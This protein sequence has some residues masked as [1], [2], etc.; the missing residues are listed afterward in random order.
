MLWRMWLQRWGHRQNHKRSLILKN[1]TVLLFVTWTVRIQLNTSA[2]GTLTLATHCLSALASFI[3]LIPSYDM[4]S[5]ITSF[6]FRNGNHC[7]NILSI[8]FSPSFPLSLLPSSSIMRCWFLLYWGSNPTWTLWM[9]R[10][11]HRATHG[12]FSLH[13]T[14]PAVL[15]QE[16]FPFSFL[17]LMS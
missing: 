17:S 16:H 12:L 1:I 8:P 5:T 13:T 4:P 2:W 3:I 15:N 6:V 7:S 11:Y 14:R 10:H 9:N